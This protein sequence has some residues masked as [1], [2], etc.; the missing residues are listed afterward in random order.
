MGQELLIPPHPGYKSSAVRWTRILERLFQLPRLGT[1]P[2]L[3]RLPTE[4]EAEVI[5]RFLVQALH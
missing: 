5:D 1:F 3:S 4:D 2:A